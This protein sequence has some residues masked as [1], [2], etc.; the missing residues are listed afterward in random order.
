MPTED[1]KDVELVEFT[2]MRVAI[3]MMNSYKNSKK[4]VWADWNTFKL[5]HALEIK[6]WIWKT[7][8]VAIFYKQ[9]IKLNNSSV[10]EALFFQNILSLDFQNNNKIWLNLL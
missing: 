6:S 8:R 7:W 2:E 1:F 9:S 4:L 10:N 5:N 3:F